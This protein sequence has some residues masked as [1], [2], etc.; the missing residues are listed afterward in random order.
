[1]AWTTLSGRA[2]HDVQGGRERAVQAAPR[3]EVPVLAAEGFAEEALPWLDAVYG[4]PRYD[5]QRAYFE[6]MQ[7]ISRQGKGSPDLRREL[8]QKLLD[9][10]AAD[11]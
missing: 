7:R 3:D 11:D 10:E 6:Y 9:Q 1:M 5:F 2:R 4:F 8:F